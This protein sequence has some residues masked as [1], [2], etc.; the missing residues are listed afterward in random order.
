MDFITLV[1]VFCIS[2][3][4]GSFYNVVGLRGLKHEEFVKTPSACPV[5]HHRLG[6]LD[7]VPVFSYAFLRGRC[8]YCNTKISKIY[9]F[10]ELLTAVSYTIIIYTHGF[11]LSLETLIQLVF[12]TFM[13]I[14]T[15]S[16]LKEH[17]IPDKI[18]AT[19]ILS[20]LFLRAVQRVGFVSYLLGGVFSFFVLFAILVLSKEKMG[21]ADVKA[22]ALIGLSI[23][24]VGAM[25]SLFYASI[26][27]LVFNLDKLKE[28]KRQN[29]IPFFPFITIGVLLVHLI[30]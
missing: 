23:G 16:D 17:I 19:G 22:Y 5:C 11:P 1:F 12:I 25:E 8:R 18:I 15:V 14:S 3:F 24:F 13:I 29:E 20:V 10:G 7:L 28:D 26:V 6:P 30:G 21:G 27:A 9:P 2:L 4:L